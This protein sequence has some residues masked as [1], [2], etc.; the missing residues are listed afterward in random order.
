MR[1]IPSGNRVLVA[2][3]ALAQSPGGLHIPANVKS[4]RG[5]EIGLVIEIGEGRTF[6]NGTVAPTGFKA[7]QRVAYLAQGQIELGGLEQKCVLLDA[8][9]V[10]GRIDDEPKG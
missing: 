7:G 5:Y 9:M 6:D 8:R 4:A 10:L 3:E 2:P 1:F